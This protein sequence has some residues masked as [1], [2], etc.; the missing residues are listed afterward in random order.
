MNQQA[1]I[2]IILDAVN[3]A[4]SALQQVRQQ[5]EDV[6]NTADQTTQKT[7]AFGTA[8]GNLG[9][10]VA[11]LA[12]T[13]GL[14]Y[15]INEATESDKSL[16]RLQL[17]LGRYGDALRNQLQPQILAAGKTI[18][19][20]GLA[21]DELASE[22]IGRLLPTYKNDLPRAING[23][24][25]LLT[26]MKYDVHGASAV[27]NF[28]GED[29]DFARAGML[30]L[31]KAVGVDVN[32][33]MDDLG[34]V[35]DRVMARL[36]NITLP[37]FV[38]EMGRLLG[39]LNTLSENVG[40][41]ILMVVNP[42]LEAVNYLFT[43]PFVGKLGEWATAITTVALSIGT[44][45]KFLGLSSTATWI[46]SGAWELLV[47]GLTAVSVALGISIG[48]VVAIGI[49]LVALGYI[50]YK[51]ITDWEGFK[52]TMIAIWD[53]IKE[54]TGKVWDWIV[55]AVQ[56]ALKALYDGINWLQDK[57]LYIIGYVVG[58]IVK[59]FLVDLPNAIGY[60]ATVFIPKAVDAIVGFFATLPQRIASALASLPSIMSNIFTAAK[61]IISSILNDIMNWVQDLPSRMLSGIT[62]GINWVIDKINAFANGFNA[63][64]PDSLKI[65]TIP[66]LADGG[67]VTKPTVALIGEAGAEAVVPLSKLGSAGGYNI[68]IDFSGSVLLS[69]GVA[70][71]IGDKIIDRL[72]KV[73]RIPSRSF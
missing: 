48:W 51:A 47:A 59:F 14:G 71:Q 4:S 52:T 3:N 7:G 69:E 54:Y 16:V 43:I 73:M 66:H 12:G 45:T 21:S 67:I 28:L 13:Y 53:A 26:L 33:K 34:E 9:D 60:F 24:S 37:P 32:P 55:K 61:N 39:N 64:V 36:K 23:A 30:R 19:G 11:G 31:A 22:T 57:M 56:T 1:N 38:Q 62:S 29:S 2:K 8:L 70:V 10:W 20:M 50:I 5:L 44:L 35:L 40:A 41:K 6:G 17:S 68:N 27:L 15:F 72:R 42:L 65:K 58:T 25:T 18:E 46:L 63:A 49:A